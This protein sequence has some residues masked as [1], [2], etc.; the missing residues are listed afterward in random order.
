LSHHGGKRKA[1][2]KPTSAKPAAPDGEFV[3]DAM[4]G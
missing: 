3:V 2:P 1:S 4:R